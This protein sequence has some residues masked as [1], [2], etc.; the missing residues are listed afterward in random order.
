MAGPQLPANIASIRAQ[1]YRAGIPS[2]YGNADRLG[3]T[4]S[5]NGY[6]SGQAQTPIDYSM[7]QWAQHQVYNNQMA[8]PELG[9]Y[10]SLGG[11]SGRG[12]MMRRLLQQQQGE[13]GMTSGSQPWNPETMAQIQQQRRQTAPNASGTMV[14]GYGVPVDPA[15]GQHYR[16]PETGGSMWMSPQEFS[17]RMQNRSAQQ[18]RMAE[19][20]KQRKMQHAERLV[21]RQYGGALPGELN[22]F[23]GGTQGGRNAGNP[24]GA[25]GFGDPGMLPKDSTPDQRQSH[26]DSLL[27]A[28]NPDASQQDIR[29]RLGQYSDEELQAMLD[30]NTGWFMDDP[31]SS[32]IGD[33]F[34]GPGDTAIENTRKRRNIL[35]RA[36]GHEQPQPKQQYNFDVGDMGGFY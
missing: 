3:T 13:T 17:R 22:Q 16:N 10:G 1:Q 23:M 21:R 12:E 33:F 8:P 28:M 24:A 35:R 7:R 9:P 32:W 14:D 29:S 36:L 30:S 19:A 34:D 4:G 27:G 15:T 26:L 2:L 18:A 20:S 31:L 6:V 5:A 25:T 11:S